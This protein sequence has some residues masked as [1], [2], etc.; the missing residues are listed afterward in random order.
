MTP[1][2]E[3]IGTSSPQRSI[4]EET[5]QDLGI[6]RIRDDDLEELGV[7]QPDPAARLDLEGSQ[8]LD[9][10][11]FDEYVEE[12]TGKIGNFFITSRL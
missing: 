2:R 5:I 1:G 12:D 11:D 7:V 3:P 9:T 4:I 10:R 6:I 8:M